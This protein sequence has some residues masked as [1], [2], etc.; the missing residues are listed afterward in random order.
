MTGEG[1]KK[2]KHEGGKHKQ[3]FKKNGLTSCLKSQCQVHERATKTRKTN[4]LITTHLFKT[5][6][7]P[8]KTF[9]FLQRKAYQQIYHCTSETGFPLLMTLTIFNV[10]PATQPT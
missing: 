4:D 1:R 7:F 3:A 5:F 8:P 9:T 10:F 6:T 2:D